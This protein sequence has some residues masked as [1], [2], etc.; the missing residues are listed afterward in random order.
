MQHAVALKVELQNVVVMYV[1][2]VRVL[3][4]LHNSGKSGGGGT[5][6]NLES[7]VLGMQEVRSHER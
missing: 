3:L 4:Q 7:Q 5:H 2:T 1:M 6:D